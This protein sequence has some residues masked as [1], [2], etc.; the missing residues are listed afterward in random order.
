LAY[1]VLFDAVV[2]TLRSKR[3]TFDSLHLYL[4]IAGSV[5]AFFGLLQYLF[6][7]DLR[8]LYDIGWDMHYGRLAGTFLDPT[9]IGLILVLNILL[10]VN[11]YFSKKEKYLILLIFL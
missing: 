2:K 9:F 7:P 4:I 6:M 11:R 10:I 8:F 5:A 1:L 3:L